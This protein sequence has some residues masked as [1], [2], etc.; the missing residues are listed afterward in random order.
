MLSKRVILMQ[1]ITGSQLDSQAA[2]ATKATKA[3]KAAKQQSLRRCAGL[4]F[5]GWHLCRFAA[6]LALSYLKHNVQK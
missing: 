3:T 5:G 4:S 1:T 6:A 2:K